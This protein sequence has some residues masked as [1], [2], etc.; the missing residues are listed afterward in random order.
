MERNYVTVTL[1]ISLNIIVILFA[2]SY[3]S[4]HI[5]MNTILEEQD[6]E[7]RQEH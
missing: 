2:Q 5:Y 3:N 4:M 6:S 7:V 1:C